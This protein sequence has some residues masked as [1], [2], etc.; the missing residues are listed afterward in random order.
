MLT[1]AGAAFS[2][3][4]LYSQESGLSALL[5]KERNPELAGWTPV[6]PPQEFKGDDLFVYIDGGAEIYLEYGFSRAVVQ[7]YGDAGGRTVS[8]ELFEMTD[9]AAAFGAYSF[10]TTG[11]GRTLDRGQGGQL[12][13]YYLNFWKGD[14]LFT[15]TG[16][17][18][19]QET[20]RGLLA[21]A[22]AAD[23]SVRGEGQPPPIIDILPAEGL[24]SGS[25]LYFKGRLGLSNAFPLAAPA[26][27]ETR[28]GVRAHYGQGSLVVLDCGEGEPVRKSFNSL[29]AIFRGGG[30]FKE[31]VESES[32]FGATDDKETPYRASVI[33][34]WI[35]IASGLETETSEDLDP[36][37][38][39]IGQPH[40]PNSRPAR[41]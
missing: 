8:L 4:A 30:R 15:I 35:L 39:I 9:P 26:N 23:H 40:G 12:E 32:A 5:P 41:P 31:F 38:A 21:V 37:E 10:K 18:D 2:P 6:G 3:S 13:D 33:K 1:V 28:Q 27:L 25:I 19:D 20:V 36:T 34:G 16:F 24:D 29:K 22:E 7:D 14:Y 17:N 11:K